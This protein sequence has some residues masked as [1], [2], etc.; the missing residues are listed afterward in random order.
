MLS[1][2]FQDINLLLFFARDTTQILDLLFKTVTLESKVLYELI[3]HTLGGD[4]VVDQ[5]HISV[6]LFCA[7][8]Q[9]RATEGVLIVL[10]F[11]FEF[12]GTR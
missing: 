4:A 3:H 8:L 11:V 7:L 9:E 2:I 12:R 10:F 1:Q 6:A 5:I